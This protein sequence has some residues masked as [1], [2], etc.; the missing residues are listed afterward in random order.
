VTA[1]AGIHCFERGPAPV[2]SCAGM[3][4]AQRVCGADPGSVWS[5]GD[6]ALGCRMQ[7]VLPQDAFDRQPLVSGGRLAL[8][9]DIRIDNRDEIVEA[10]RV[11]RS[12]ARDWCD[13][14]VLLAA[15]ECWEEGCVDRILGDYA[16]AV[17]DAA[18]RRLLLARDPLGQRPLHYHRGSGFFAFASMPKGLH[19][20]AGVPYRPDIERLAEFLALVPESGPRTF[21]H[22]VE[23]V[24]P[25]CLVTVTCR[26]LATQRFW[27]PR[28]RPLKLADPADYVHALREHLDRAV[29][30]RLRGAGDVAAHLSAGLDSSAVAAT[31]ARLLQPAAG[32]VLAFTAAPRAGYDGSAHPG[33]I[34]DEGR[35]AAATA[36]MH[37]NIEHVLIRPAGR[38]PLDELERSFALFDRPLSSICNMV[39]LFAV[40]DR[41]QER[42]L[43]V[44]LNGQMGNVGM[45]YAGAELLC[46]LFAGGRWLRWR[47]EARALA[48]R[49]ASWPGLVARTISPWLPDIRAR[50]RGGPDVLGYAAL[51]PGP[52]ETFGLCARARAR[53]PAFGG[54]SWKDGLSMRLWT[55]GHV[56]PGSFNKGVLGGWGIDLRDPL[57]DRRL[58]EFCLSVP[59][60][61]FLRNGEFRSLARRA[62]QDRLPALVVEEQR[63]GY[64]AADWHEALA[65]ARGRIAVELARLAACA[66]AAALLDLPRLRRLVESWPSAGWNRGDVTQLYRGTLLRALTAGYFLRRVGERPQVSP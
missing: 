12:V 40:N 2:E 51:A 23:R 18:R 21:F 56:D 13:A 25:G 26:D 1:L 3:L 38:S 6:I 33:A 58:I 9:A 54:R 17:W 19:A 60:E 59:T 45:S 47:C 24:E 44:L 43:T 36:A 31:A 61:Q 41:V 14:A 16:F 42:G 27:R 35:H 46:E 4:A 55:L 20:L 48:T 52:V 66:P 22:A 62:L 10:L 34:P 49:G 64:Q 53:N 15:F 29:R 57:A 11:P 65:A 30:A 39:W 63:S 37:P 7:P 50:W 32:R 28:P 5:G 8:V